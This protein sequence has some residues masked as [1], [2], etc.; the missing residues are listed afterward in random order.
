MSYTTPNTFNLVFSY[1]NGYY[2]AKSIQNYP[3]YYSI[4]DI[5][6]LQL[7]YGSNLN[8]NTEDNVYKFLYEDSSYETIWDAGGM[9]TL[10]LSNNLGNTTLDLNGGT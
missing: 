9:D 1:D 6:A 5:A 8:S 4:Y 7:Q 2:Y 10:D 3:A